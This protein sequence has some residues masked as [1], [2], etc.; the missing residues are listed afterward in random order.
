MKKKEVLH[1]LENC[2]RTASKAGA[3]LSLKLLI[4]LKVSLIDNMKSNLICNWNGEI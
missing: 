2:L 4:E 1:I 3:S